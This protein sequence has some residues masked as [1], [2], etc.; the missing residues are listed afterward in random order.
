MRAVLRTMVAVGVV[1]AFA[2]ACSAQ[3]PPPAAQRAPRAGMAQRQPGAE[4]G[5]DFERLL[6]PG[7]EMR[8]L[9][10][11]LKLSDDQRQAIAAIAQKTAE[12]MKPLASQ[13]PA[14]SK[15]LA[16]CMLVD[17]PDADQAKEL[18]SQVQKLREQMAGLGVDFWVQVRQKLTADQNGK[19]T[20][21]LKERMEQGWPPRGPMA[22]GQP[23]GRGPRP[24]GA[25]P[26]P[27]GPGQ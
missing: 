10:D 22:P 19:L 12:Q 14:L 3:A 4:R 1:A 2:S 6:R 13:I 24:D 20:Q 25:A 5:G 23:G 11:E 7:F 21:I 8:R 9:G 15:Q 26:Q 17:K 16:D 18:I 27:D